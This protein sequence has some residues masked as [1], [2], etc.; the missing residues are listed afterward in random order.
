MVRAFLVVWAARRKLKSEAGQ[1]AG[2]DENQA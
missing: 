1:G 2:Q